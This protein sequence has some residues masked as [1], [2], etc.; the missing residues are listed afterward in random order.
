MK[1]VAL[2]LTLALA[3]TSLAAC[4]EDSTSG[5][6]AS[7]GKATVVTAFYPLEYLVDRIGGDHV[8][9]Q[10]LTAPGAEPHELELTPKQIAEASKADL[11]VYEKD[12]QPAVDEAF[13][14]A[15]PKK[16]LDVATAA[17]LTLS[18]DHDAD[19]GEAEHEHTEGDGHDHGGSGNDPHFW[20]DPVRYAKVADAVATSL[21]EAS[22]ANKATFE[23]NL[24]ALKKDL[25]ALD[26]E[27][28]AGLA[29]CTSKNVVTSHA[30]F[31]YLTNRYGLKQV[32]ISGISPEQE[33]E[34]AQLA[35]IAA[36]AKANKVTTIY[37]ETLASPAIA[38][39]VAAETGATTAVLDPIEGITKASAAQDYL[40][41]MRANLAALKKGQ[42]CS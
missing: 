8:E 11:G 25:T 15:A 42:S 7:G 14:N 10:S 2:P 29:S 30:A 35:E 23:T 13:A 33:P 20:L 3:A 9:V 21:S 1:R 6:T 40:G 31:G 34:P 24:A 4:G 27:L 22:P 19:V 39:T 17:D 12:F 41:V 16:L 36:Y 5:S 32:A 38:K 37:T 28:E 26:G 18:Y